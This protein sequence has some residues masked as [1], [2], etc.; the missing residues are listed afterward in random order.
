M[1]WRGRRRSRNIVDRRGRAPARRGG[2]TKPGR[3]GGIGLVVVVLAA[4]VFGVDPSF[5]LQGGGGQEPRAVRPLT[6]EDRAMGDFV[7]VVLADTEEV[8]TTIFA[9]QL[10]RPYRPPELVL[11]RGVT[12]SP[13]GN[14]S[15]ATGPFYCPTDNRAYLDTDFFVTLGRRLGAGGD[16]AAAYVVAHEVAHHVQD[17]LGILGDANAA[18]SRASAAEANAISVRIELQ[19]IACRGS[20]PGRRRIAL[21]RWSQ[22][23]WKR[24]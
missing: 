12:H 14:A 3:L 5:L 23:I 22:A 17:Q 9:R 11:F 24:R 7:S 4:V 8:W 13:C 18:R 19:P 2:A 1:K 10:G 16:F 6:E 15:G 20:G 21:G